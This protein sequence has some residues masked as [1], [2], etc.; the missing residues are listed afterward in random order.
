MQTSIN[1]VEPEPPPATVSNLTSFDKHDLRP[2]CVR[3]IHATD[4]E[5]D[6]LPYDAESYEGRND[7]DFAHL[8]TFDDDTPLYMH[9]NTADIS[10]YINTMQQQSTDE[11]FSLHTIENSIHSSRILR[12]RININD[13]QMDSGANKNV[14]NDKSII[15]NFS[16]IAPMPIYGVDNRDISCHITGKSVTE[17][18]TIDGLP[19]EIQMYY[20][21]HCSGTILSP[22]AIVTQSNNFT[23]WIQTSHLDTG[24]AQILFYHRTD[25]TKNKTLPMV[26]INNLWFVQQDYFPLVSKANR[27]KV[28]FL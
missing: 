24:K 20:S 3:L 26:L 7:S 1:P 5:Q 11:I 19:L 12:M 17:I 27:T 23:S 14:T 6:V 15:R 16:S 21:P 4:I 13:Q 2:L 28:C 8:T 9:L 10:S 25:F 22:N 18:N